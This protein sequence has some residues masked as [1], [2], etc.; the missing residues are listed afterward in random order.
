LA[1]KIDR[2]LVTE[3]RERIAEMNPEVAKLAELS[4]AYD[5][6]YR[7]SEQGVREAAQSIGVLGLVPSTPAAADTCQ[8]YTMSGAPLPEV[9]K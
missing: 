8:P 4:R 1:S 7:S 9:A 2:K 5:V 3:A 6:L